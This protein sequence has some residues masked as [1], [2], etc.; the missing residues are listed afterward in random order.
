MS[1]EI[2]I[3]RRRLLQASGC[4]FAWLAASGIAA[5]SARSRSAAAEPRPVE[6]SQSVTGV[7]PGHHFASRAKRIIFLFMQGGPSHV[8]TFDFKPNMIKHDGQ[9][10]PFDDSRSIAKTGR[11]GDLHR[12]MKSPWQFRQYGEGGH[13]VSDLFPETAKHADD[14]CM[15]HSMHTEGVAHGPATLFLHTG[16]TNSIRPS[17][18]SWVHYGLGEPIARA[19]I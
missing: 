19:M 13:W 11:R 7:A 3:P 8:D 6:E 15:I 14:L 16:A 1:N 17:M 9:S 4:G 18:G 5:S 2:L 10:M 12:V